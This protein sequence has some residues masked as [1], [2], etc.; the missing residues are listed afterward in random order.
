MS[1]RSNKNGG[2]N[3]L[4]FPGSGTPVAPGPA[5]PLPVLIV[6]HQETSTP[7]RVGNALRALGTLSISGVRGLA[8]P[9]RRRLTGTPAPSSSAAR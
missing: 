9:C 3:I 7:G 2:G 6:L 8:M 1:F 5:A 4:P